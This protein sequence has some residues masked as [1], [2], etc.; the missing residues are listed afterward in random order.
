VEIILPG[1]TL[2]F[3]EGGKYSRAVFGRRRYRLPNTAWNPDTCRRSCD[4]EKNGRSKWMFEYKLSKKEENTGKK[5]MK[6]RNQ[7]RR[8]DK[9]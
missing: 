8:F 3:L 5:A 7:G 2:F 4:Q 9:I 6:N 1:S